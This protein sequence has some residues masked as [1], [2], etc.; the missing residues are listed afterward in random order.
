MERN[1]PLWQKI[2]TASHGYFLVDLLLYA[3]F[4]LAYYLLVLQFLGDRVKQIFDD[5]RIHYAILALT[6]IVVQ[7][8]FLEMLTGA[9][10][11]LIRRKSR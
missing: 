4:V 2:K 11:R 5:S 6:L 9:L 7:G 3:V 1:T 10:M 8:V